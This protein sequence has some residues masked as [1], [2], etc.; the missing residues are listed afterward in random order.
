MKN[1]KILGLIKK[2]KNPLRLLKKWK[3]IYKERLQK[4]GKEQAAVVAAN[5]LI[6][7]DV[8]K[9]FLTV[10]TLKK[11]K[12]MLAEMTRPSTI[13]TFM[14][15][16]NACLTL[17]TDGNKL[18]KEYSLHHYK[19]KIKYISDD[20]VMEVFRQ[21][22]KE[23]D[24]IP[25]ENLYYVITDLN[26]AT[27]RKL[28]KNS[29]YLKSFKNEEVFR[30]W[31]LQRDP[32]ATKERVGKF[33][34]WI[35]NNRSEMY[36]PHI[37]M[38][39]FNFFKNKKSFDIFNFRN[40]DELLDYY[41]KFKRRKPE[42]E[43][44]PLF[45]IDGNRFY[46][47]TNFDDSKYY[48][49]I[50]WCIS[51]NEADWEKYKNDLNQFY[52]LITP[53][54]KWAIQVNNY[55]TEASVWSIKNRIHA[56]AESRRIFVKKYKSLISKIEEIIERKIMHEETK[57]IYVNRLKGNRKYIE[58]LTKIFD[59]YGPEVS[60]E[61]TKLC[62]KLG[63]KYNIENSIEVIEQ[64]EGK[65]IIDIKNYAVFVH[66]EKVRSL[67][68][69]FGPKIIIN[70]IWDSFS[71]EGNDLVS[72]EG[73][74]K[75]VTGNYDFQYNKIKS[76]KGIAQFIG[77]NI[78]GSYNQL[79]SLEGFPRDFKGVAYFNDNSVS[80]EEAKKYQEKGYNIK[81]K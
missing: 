27:V 3:R 5:A 49:S 48:G 33:S 34:D 52:F 55:A 71:C 37:V 59:K 75:S 13:G 24:Y 57:K 8:L 26:E 74:P 20:Y 12:K 14:L 35:I 47:I 61:L 54:T 53:S 66:K 19:G 63:I 36:E 21:L 38:E 64:K 72:L 18:N 60:R 4:N 77:G 22:Y 76:L 9:E 68:D 16:P 78:N 11:K 58:N 6:R 45:N 15:H 50:N 81:I 40:F 73:G 65:I 46:K 51:R 17:L 30:K 28:Y 29:P 23:Y 31:I 69:F 80:E 44:K 32:T 67:K 43:L 2:S 56:D 10:D 7:S 25:E 39:V 79:K 62:L 70:K 1:K 42:D 41:K